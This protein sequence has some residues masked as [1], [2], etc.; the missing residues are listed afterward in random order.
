MEAIKTLLSDLDHKA[1][2]FTSYIAVRSAR[3]EALVD[4]LKDGEEI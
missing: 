3:I 2:P 1:T 4:N